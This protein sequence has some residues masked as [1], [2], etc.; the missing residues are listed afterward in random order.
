MSTEIDGVTG[1]AF[2]LR[3]SNSEL[4]QLTAGLDNLTTALNL[5]A[6]EQSLPAELLAKLEAATTSTSPAASSE[7]S[8][9]GPA[10]AGSGSGA[11][12]GAGSGSGAGAGAGSGS[13]AGADG[14]ATAA[15]V[16]AALVGVAPASVVARP[17]LLA[18]LKGRTA[19]KPSAE[20]VGA[21][22]VDILKRT[23]GEGGR[24]RRVAYWDE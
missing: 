3:Q 9:E 18:Q 17:N 8:E 15:K 13:G 16:G 1:I 20:D 12:A 14:T 2:A 4:L 21:P 10:G 5:F 7:P 11:G 24:R 23:G 22:E 6:G 19:K